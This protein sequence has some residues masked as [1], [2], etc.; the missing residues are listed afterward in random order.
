ML[1]VKNRLAGFTLI[2][3]LIALFCLAAS[4]LFISG[5]VKQIPIIRQQLD[6]NRQQEWHAFL[7]QLDH[8][9]SDWEYALNSSAILMFKKGSSILKIERYGDVIRKR[10]NN[11]GHQPLLTKVYN[12]KFSLQGSAIKIWVQ[13][14]SGEEYE[15]WWFPHEKATR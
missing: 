13:F 7:H 14:E 11:L 15:T 1:I 2:E 9:T 10:V 12:S 4:L 8:E 5:F 6:G 3:C